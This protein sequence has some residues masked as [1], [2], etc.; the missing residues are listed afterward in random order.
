MDRLPLVKIWYTSAMKLP[1][2][3]YL[4]ALVAAIVA[5]CGVLYPEY[6]SIVGQLLTNAVNEAAP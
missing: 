6:A 2:K 3:K 4:V 5:A 1:P